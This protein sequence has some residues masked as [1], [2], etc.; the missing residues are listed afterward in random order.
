MKIGL[1][2][3]A[4]AE[5]EWLKAILNHRDQHFGKNRSDVFI[6]DLNIPKPDLHL[7]IGSGTHAEQTGNLMIAFERLC[8]DHRPD[9]VLVVGDV[10]ATVA[11][12]L[13]AAKLRIP[14][15]HSAT[16]RNP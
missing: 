5:R 12:S 8:L 10:N 16:S 1:I 9:M 15:A 11:C 2:M 7:G 6:N 13:T 3:K 14:V 4:L